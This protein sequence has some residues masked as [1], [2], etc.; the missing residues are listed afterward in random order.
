MERTG[1]SSAA[2]DRQVHGAR[3][4]V[5]R[6][7][8]PGL[9]LANG[10]DGHATV[11]PGIL[12]TVSVADCVP[13]F[14]VAP[15]TPGIAL[16]HG[17]WRGT[18]AGILERGVDA[19]TGLTGEG[20]ED[21]ALHLGPAICGDCYKVG[22]EVHE[23][24]GL[25][26]PPGPRPVDLRAV[27]S[28]RASSLGLREISISRHCTLCGDSPFFS[29]RGGAAGRQLGI[30]GLR[31]ADAG[32]GAPGGSPKTPP[33]LCGSCLHA[34][35][36]RTRRGSEFLLCDRSRREPDFPRYPPLPVRECRG[37]EKRA[38]GRRKDGP[39]TA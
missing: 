2:H 3:V 36:I 39:D 15:R 25:A 31:A 21:L 5:H 23:A 35:D 22:P 32:R 8:A 26:R 38:G 18:A 16:L 12:L 10:H 27:L 11:Q 34:R 28:E 20:V 7:P 37:F 33:G 4:R 17:G 29:H 6:N 30:L 13:I 24:L 9:I 19:L 14:L 1:F